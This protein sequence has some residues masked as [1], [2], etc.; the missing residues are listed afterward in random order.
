MKHRSPLQ[1]GDHPKLDIIKFLNEDDKEIYQFL[2]GCGQWNIS[3]RRFDT[4]SAMNINMVDPIDLIP[5]STTS[6]TW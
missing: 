4:Q 2:I 3:I 1:K 5:A 6:K